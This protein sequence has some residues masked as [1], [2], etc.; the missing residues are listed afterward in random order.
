MPKEKKTLVQTIKDNIIISVV[1]IILLGA[2]SFVG[3]VTTNTMKQVGKNTEAVIRLEEKQSN[4]TNVLQKL[5][6]EL[7]EVSVKIE[8][9]E[10]S[11]ARL[12]EI[13]KILREM[14][15]Q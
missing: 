11:T 2:L 9:L 4:A 1:S 12:D 7:S 13:V 15:M 5:T 3:A 6:N 8:K 14:A 10:N